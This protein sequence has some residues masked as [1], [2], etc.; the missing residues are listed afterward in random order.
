MAHHD[1][2]TQLANRLTFNERLADALTAAA[3]GEHGLALLYL[4]LDGFK[5][6][7]NTGHRPH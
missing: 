6:V 7:N 4:D 1:D 5:L 3:C 2:L